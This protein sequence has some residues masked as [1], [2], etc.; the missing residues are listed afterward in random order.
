MSYRTKAGEEPTAD[1]GAV[2]CTASETWDDVSADKESAN[3]DAITLDYLV[4]IIGFGLCRAWII[5]CLGAPLVAGATASYN[6]MYLVFG[7]LSALAVSFAVKRDGKRESAV[8][9]VLMRFAPFALLA[10]GILLPV[11]L[12]LESE[13][14]T[15]LGFVVGGLGAG[16]LQVLWGDRFAQHSTRFAAYASPAAAIITALVAA[17]STDHTSFIGFAL[18]PLLSFALLVFEA[19]RTGLPLSSV[20]KGS[21]AAP[22][23]NV[24][25][26]AC[27]AAPKENT[28]LERKDGTVGLGVGKLM[29]SIM[30]FS[31][32]CRLFDATPVQNDP[33]SFLG[34]SAMFALILVGIVFLGIV[35]RLKERFNPTLTYRLSLPIMVAGFVAI[36]LFFDTHT[37][38]S[39]LLINVGYEFFDILAW[40][41]FV[42][43][44]KRRNEN[45]LHIFG[46]G[47]AFM[48]AGMALGTRAGCIIDAMVTSGDLQITAVAMMAT[49]CLV[50]VAFMV[51]PEG[52]VTQLSSTMRTGR[53][54][55]DDE[56]RGEV[57]RES[58]DTADGE[59]GAGRI[60]Q[61]CSCVARDFGL[62]PRESEVIVLLAY[63]RTLSIIARDLQIAKGTARTHIEN[64][65]RKLDVHKQQ[66]LIDLVEGYDHPSS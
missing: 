31:V 35:A 27:Q 57:P 49:L 20:L 37:A 66:E 41:L 43:A 65:Y 15:A 24:A 11:A 64:I 16:P 30:I 47:V 56:G 52:V 26:P 50:V 8:R 55:R 18:I 42:E 12:W 62:T 34:G 6:W 46:L 21:T 53:K 10:S 5:F 54:E 32:L 63:G 9:I 3:R 39:I 36:A 51:L 59:V 13:P 28:A 22:G 33:F 40:V 23:E 48:F 4:T 17:L 2:A 1:A 19:G 14:L 25:L 58:R 7:A 45:A 44:S 38:V 29:F 61:H 60:E